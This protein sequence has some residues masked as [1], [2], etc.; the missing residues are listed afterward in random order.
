MCSTFRIYTTTDVIGVE[1][2]GAL[3]NVIALAAGVCDG[4]RLGDNT[5]AALITRG[6]AEMKRL[7]VCMGGKQRTFLGLAGVGDLIVTCTSQHSR[8]NRFGY[9]VGSGVPVDVALKEVGTVEGYYAAL[10]AHELSKKYNIDIPII[11]KCYELLYCN[12]DLSTVVKDLMVR[13]VR[14]EN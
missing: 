3:K 10:M 4:L 7:G 1:L 12:G 2:G 9:K 11:N 6:L 8:N 14:S 13:P 5:K